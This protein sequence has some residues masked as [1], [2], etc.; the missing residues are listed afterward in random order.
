[1]RLVSQ[2]ILSGVLAVGGC[3]AVAAPIDV[4]IEWTGPGI[5]HVTAKNYE[6]LGFGQGYAVARDRLCLLADRVITLRGERSRRYGAEQPA[7]VGFVPTT[8]LSSDLFHRVQLSADGVAEAAK[9]LDA[10]VLELARGYAAGFNRYVREQTPQELERRCPG[11]A[12]PRMNELDVVRAMQSI[13][14]IWKASQ[15]APFAQSSVWGRDSRQAQVTDTPEPISL[16]LGSNA[17]AYGA[18]VTRNRGAIVIANPHSFWRG[19]WLSMHQM[20]LRIPGEIDVA[21]ADFVG[22]P[23]PVAGFNRDVAWTL[24]APSTVTYFVLQRLAVQEGATPG[25]VVEGKRKALT[26]R[27]IDLEVK[28]ADGS[29]ARESFPIAY[30]ELGPIYRLPERSGRPAG[31]Y[32]IT[33]AGDGNVEGLNQLLHIAKARD[34]N[35]FVDAIER[36][37]GVGAHFIAGDRHGDVVYVESGPLL[38]ITDEALEDCR[39][40]GASVP[41]N[42]LDGARSAC[43]IRTANGSPRNLPSAKF[44]LLRGR[45][46]IHNT[47]G[48]YRFSMHG[49]DVQGFSRLFGNPLAEPFNLRSRM[50]QRRMNEITADGLVSDAEA[51]SV[52]FDNRNYAAETWL[53]ALLAVCG[54]QAGTPREGC[55]V[56]SEWDRR[57]DSASRG[58]LLFG[59]FWKRLNRMEGLFVATADAAKPF[60]ARQLATTESAKQGI[61][62]ALAEAVAALKAIGLSGAEPWGRILS[63][64]TSKERV[65]LHGGP[66]DQGV[67]N[68]IEGSGLGRDGFDE[69]VAGTDYLHLVQ[70]QDGALVAQTL[71]AHG[72]SD[73]PRSAHFEDQLG[74]FSNKQLTRFPFTDAAIRADPRRTTLRLRDDDGAAV[75]STE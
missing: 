58:A 52:V 60:T 38:D 10:R 28:R 20:H 67:L 43:A 64:R 75:R 7:V 32:A 54:Q 17:W 22:L 31:W 11:A 50:S 8:N 48:S 6:S 69:I 5:P 2:V 1:M 21:G 63:A 37:R 24:E 49:R 25:Y 74:K 15:V 30:S 66:A 62:T 40:E 39:I 42:V 53:D 34:V 4:T 46:V 55:S 61:A 65:P 71:L 23:L 47:N 3:S 59:E 9:R 35:S 27:P 18:D 70:W 26:I 33:D 12:M 51:L 72:Q 41:F 14:T 29:I 68:A 16:S 13:G 57:N 19:H 73:D 36:N 44:P 45:G 56:L